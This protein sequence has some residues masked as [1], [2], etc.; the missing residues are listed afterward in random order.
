[1]GTEVVLPLAQLFGFSVGDVLAN[2]VNY[3]YYILFGAILASIIISFI[4]RY[5]SSGFF[6]AVYDAVRA[7]VNPILGPIRSVIPPLRIGGFGLDLSPIIA[8]IG[9]SIASNLLLL[10]I[11]EFIRPITG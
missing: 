9:L 1:M 6:Q 2:I 11:D 8:I 10:V 3:A 4:P 7:I 5:P